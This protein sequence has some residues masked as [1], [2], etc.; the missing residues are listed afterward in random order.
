MQK[1]L[2]SSIQADG[3]FGILPPQSERQFSGNERQ[4]NPPSF[5]KR[6][7]HRVFTGSFLSILSAVTVLVCGGCS[8]TP[9]GPVPKQ[10]VTQTPGA[11]APGD[12]LKLSFPGA[13]ELNQTQKVRADGRI[14]APMLGEVSASGKRLGQLQ[15]ELSQLYKPQLKNSEVVVTLEA[16]AIPVYVSGAVLRPGKVALDRPMTLIEAIMEAGGFV[17]DVAN[18]KKVV[19]IRNIRGQQTTHIFDL[20]PALR[21]KTIE[22]FPLRAYDIIYVQQGF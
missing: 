6:R 21:G 9:P 14:S 18:P 4:E 7:A 5:E 2:N 19:V 8:S 11:L 3:A 12:V 20:S 17:P 22:A 10:W 16:S 1:T 13:P 15:S